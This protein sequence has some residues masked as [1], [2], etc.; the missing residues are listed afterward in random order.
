MEYE[1]AQEIVTAM[2]SCYRG[3]PTQADKYS[4]HKKMQALT[5]AVGALRHRMH[6]REVT[7]KKYIQKKE[8]RERLN[9]NG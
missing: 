6:R 2:Q 8:Y 7:H 5:C 9:N 1:E 3:D 4:E